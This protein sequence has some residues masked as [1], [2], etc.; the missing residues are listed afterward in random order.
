MF[1]IFPASLT[2]FPEIDEYK[3]ERKETW[4]VIDRKAK[5]LKENRSKS[6]K[7]RKW[8]EDTREL[9]KDAFEKRNTPEWR[10]KISLSKKGIVLSEETKNKSS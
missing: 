6:S 3:Q 2:T 8:S 7:G 10:E 9:M 4:E 5:E 1:T